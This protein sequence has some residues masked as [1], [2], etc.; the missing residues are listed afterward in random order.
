MGWEE[1]WTAPHRGLRLPE[2]KPELRENQLDELMCT[3]C[4]T[5][6]AVGAAAGVVDRDRLIWSKGYGYADLETSTPFDPAATIINIASIS[7]VIT[8]SAVLQLVEDGRLHLDDPVDRFIDFRARHPHHSTTDI[9]VR[10]LLTHKSAIADSTAYKESY[11]AGDPDPKVAIWLRRYLDPSGDLFDVQRNWH[12]WKP[13]DEWA[14]SS[15]A[16]ALLAPVVESASGLPFHVYTREMIF[17]RSGMRSTAWF[18]SDID[19]RR[20]SALY[21]SR[22]DLAVIRANL[23]KGPSV[24]SG[25]WQPV[26]H[27]GW[28]TYPDGLVRTTLEDLSRFA[29]AV[30][31]PAV[32]RSRSMLTLETIREM[33]SDVVVPENHGTWRGQL[34]PARAQGLGWR[35]FVSMTRPAVWGH[36]GWDPGVRTLLLIDAEAKLGVILMTNTSATL[37][38]DVDK[39]LDAAERVRG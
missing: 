39:L 22:D 20:L 10:H 5:T 19:N 14:Y 13:G 2:M 24:R 3:W 30:L 6:D 18:L 25:K 12:P 35:R 7:K 31:A 37:P 23:A 9:T 36:R 16:T 11:F 15:I 38:D 32:S 21:S 8:A 4:E 29:I 34:P 26:V 28:P 27:Y 33:L 17:A 1:T